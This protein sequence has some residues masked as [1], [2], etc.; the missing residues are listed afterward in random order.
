M[1]DWR[2]RGGGKVNTR[3]CPDIGHSRGNRGSSLPALWEDRVEF[4]LECF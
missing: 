1:G 3:V 2:E 4:A